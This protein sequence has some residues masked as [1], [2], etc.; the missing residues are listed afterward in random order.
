[1]ITH[2][3]WYLEK[4]KSYDAETLLIDR[5]LN[6]YHFYKIKIMQKML[7]KLIPD[8]F[9]ILVNNPKQPLDARN[10]FKNKI[11]WKHY[12]KAMKKLTLFFVQTQSL[13]MDKTRI[14]DQSLFR[15]Q[16]KFRKIIIWSSFCVIPKFTLLIN[17]SQFMAL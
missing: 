14:S 11:F 17:A 15:L 7:L 12:Q 6:K 3:V 2:F 4:E 16:N 8:P 5:V 9:V 1:M 13:L 10:S